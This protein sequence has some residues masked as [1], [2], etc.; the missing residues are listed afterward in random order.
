MGQQHQTFA[1]A[2][3]DPSQN[4]AGFTW[5]SAFSDPP[6][7]YVPQAYPNQI[8]G[9]HRSAPDHGR[10]VLEPDGSAHTEAGSIKLLLDVDVL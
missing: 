10:S 3:K 1:E 5:Q 4:Q 7:C 2:R 8:T 6:V 9:L